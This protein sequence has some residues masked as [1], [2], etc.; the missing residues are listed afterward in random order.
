[1][2]S[3]GIVAAALLLRLASSSK[4][5]MPTAREHLASILHSQS[6]LSRQVSDTLEL[7]DFRG[8]HGVSGPWSS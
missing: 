3:K 5:N 2:C 6:F 8:C 4:T 7:I 1:M